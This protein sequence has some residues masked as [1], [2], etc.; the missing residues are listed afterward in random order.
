MLL[1]LYL[2]C[3][4]EPYLLLQTYGH[5]LWVSWHYHLIACTEPENS[6][7][8]ALQV[9]VHKLVSIQS[10]PLWIPWGQGLLIDNNHAL[11]PD[12]APSNTQV[13]SEL[14]YIHASLWQQ[15]KRA[16]WNGG[17][18][19]NKQIPPPP[20]PV[21]YGRTGMSHALWSLFPSHF[22]EHCQLRIKWLLA[23]LK[24][25]LPLWI[26]ICNLLKWLAHVFNS[27]DILWATRGWDL[28]LLFNF[29]W[30]LG[31]L[32]G[33]C[34]MLPNLTYSSHDCFSKYPSLHCYVP[35]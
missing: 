23:S 1:S 19:E 33:C 32:S 10:S 5:A 12:S 2:I 4:R 34:S 7:H 8:P 25:M 35:P 20:N 6:S 27:F 30:N 16:F 13:S 15:M 18:S 3:F 11:A 24:M 26:F 28:G 31:F 14:V 29:F 21:L 17:I 22:W 9:S